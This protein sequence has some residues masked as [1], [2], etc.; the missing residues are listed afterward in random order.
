M[1]LSSL[2]VLL[3]SLAQSPAAE[4]QI[5]VWNDPPPSR[6]TAL[7]ARF[8]LFGTGVGVRHHLLERVSTELAGFALFGPR[9]GQFSLSFDLRMFL[10]RRPKFWFYICTPLIWEQQAKPSYVGVHQVPDNKVLRYSNY[11][12]GIGPGV[13]LFVHPLVSLSMSLPF[14]WIRDTEYP[15]YD[16]TEFNPSL[17]VYVY[18]R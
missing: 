10:V 4:S 18:F 5:K 13:E 2:G 17:G 9:G 11:F 12:A 1:M 6:R 8:G 7:T 15:R 16:S 14:G 3:L